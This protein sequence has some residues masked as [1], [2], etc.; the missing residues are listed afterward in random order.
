VQSNPASLSVGDS[1][2]LND[3]EGP[4]LH[5]IVAQ[6][7]SLDEDRVM[8][9]Y[10]SSTK[11]HQDPTTIINIGEHPFVTKQSWVRYQNIKVVQRLS[12][13]DKISTSYGKVSDSL[14]LRIQNGVLH[15]KF[16]AK[17]KRE[18]FREWQD[19]EIYKQM[20]K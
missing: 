9:V 20:S 12:L 16:V 19:D 6:E 7:G 18:L 11:S 4:H 14:L 3:L 8:M 5:I 10:L 15:S 1:F 17:D 2:V 13:T